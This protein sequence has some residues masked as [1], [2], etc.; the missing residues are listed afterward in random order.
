MTRKLLFLAIN[1]FLIQ[2]IL[3]IKNSSKLKNKE[4]NTTKVIITTTSLNNSLSFT[5]H[6][7]NSSQTNASYTN[8]PA[9]TKAKRQLCKLRLLKL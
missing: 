3:S 1:L 2:S 5:E 9:K 7:D 4:L 6:F 8:M